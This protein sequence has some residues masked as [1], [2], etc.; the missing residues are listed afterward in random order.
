MNFNAFLNQLSGQKNL[1]FILLTAVFLI[2]ALL[3]TKFTGYKEKTPGLL[4]WPHH[5]LLAA[6]NAILFRLILPGFCLFIARLAYGNGFG[7]FNQI[8]V[9]HTFAIIFTIIFLDWMRYYLHRVYHA[10]P[11]LWKIHRLHH[12]DV[13]VDITT[14]L[15][16]HPIEL[17]ITAVVEAWFIYMLGAPIAG[18]FLFELW[19]GISNL[20]NHSNIRISPRLEKALRWVIPTPDMHRVHHSSNP[21]ETNRNFGF[22]F[23]WW[24]RLFMTYHQPLEPGKIK[25]GQNIFEEMLYF[26]LKELLLQPFYDKQ[27]KFKL[28]NIT[29]PD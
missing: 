7:L 29:H 15:R 20:F 8:R 3:E 10:I 13:E 17:L 11:S 18:V 12:T 5:L 19:I 21:S 16:F 4:R 22:N 2:L 25:F 14:G 23:S 26:R 27:G 1:P 28:K 9:P 6:F 24:D